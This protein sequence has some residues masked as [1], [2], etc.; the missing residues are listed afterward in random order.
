MSIII[1]NEPVKL[2]LEVA[3]FEEVLS[4]VIVSLQVEIGNSS[5]SIN[6]NANDI[7]FECKAWD[8]FVSGLNQ[9]GSG[10]DKAALTSISDNLEIALRVVDGV[11]LFSIKWK[12][13]FVDNAANLCVDFAGRVNLDVLSHLQEKFNEFPKWW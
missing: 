6:Y 10:E 1:I 12:K 11:H 3:E 4:S 9:I 8:E 2:Q 13:S 7:W 5:G